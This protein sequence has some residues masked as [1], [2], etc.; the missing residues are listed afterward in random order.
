MMYTAQQ[1]AET[2]GFSI[3][4][5][6]QW[7]WRYKNKLLLPAGV[8]DLCDR[9]IQVGRTIRIDS[10]DVEDWQARQRGTLRRKNYPDT[11]RSELIAKAKLLAND[12]REVGAE[13][14]ADAFELGSRLLDSELGRGE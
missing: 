7:R 11:P 5:I 6:Y 13:L 10:R 1:L 14:A 2:I 8:G 3:Q 9:F 4:T 12:S